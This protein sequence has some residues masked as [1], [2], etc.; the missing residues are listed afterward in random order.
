MPYVTKSFKPWIFLITVLV[1][2]SMG[3]WS[4]NELIFNYFPHDYKLI[5][6]S[7]SL[8]TL[9]YQGP[10]FIPLRMEG[11]NVSRTLREGPQVSYEIP[12]FE[13]LN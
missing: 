4:H 12:N 2:L 6:H 10:N 13:L 3:S 9:G 1:L 11:K 8:R 5:H 7:L